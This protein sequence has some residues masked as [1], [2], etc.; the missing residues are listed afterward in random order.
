MGTTSQT[1]YITG[2]YGSNGPLQNKQL[3]ETW[4]P[5][6]SGDSGNYGSSGGT[7][8]TGGFKFIKFEVP[9]DAPKNLYYRCS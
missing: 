5:F 7:G 9:D 6:T 2:V 4:T 8:T 3:H 1:K